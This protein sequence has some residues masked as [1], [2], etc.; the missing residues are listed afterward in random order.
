YNK[1]E[2]PSQL[3]PG[4]RIR[5]P[6]AMPDQIWQQKKKKAR[7]A[8]RL[9][10]DSA[11]SGESGTVSSTDGA[12][13]TTG[14][15][16]VT[17]ETPAERLR[18]DDVNNPPQALPPATLDQVLATARKL[19]GAGDLPAAIHTLESEGS[20]YANIKAVQTLQID[21]SREYADLLVKTDDL[22]GA[23]GVLEK[24]ILLDGSNDQTVNSLIRVED[25]L[26]SRKLYQRGTDLLGQDHVEE[27]YNVFTQ[28]LTYD[29]DNRMARQAQLESRD[30]LTD[31]YHRLAMQHF[32]R[33]ELDQAI[34]L[35]DR[36]LRIDPDHTLAA[37]YKARAVVM[38]QKLEQIE[39]GK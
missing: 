11:A 6:G 3:A 7:P 31:S 28:A 5:V 8:R 21:Y 35:W 19:H 27:A 37:G 22:E 15:Q 2:N 24:L 14:L 13:T 4:D 18:T 12:A 25:K 10:A 32:R 36:I 39:S 1:L 16:A 30:K 33:Q 34:A 20:R 38:K 9:S 26:E 23:R 17:A 29:P